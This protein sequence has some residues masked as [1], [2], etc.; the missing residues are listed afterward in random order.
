MTA[1][2]SKERNKGK[3][4]NIGNSGMAGVEVGVGPDEAEVEVEVA[5]IVTVCV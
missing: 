5:G 4:A 2:Q 3:M 1:P